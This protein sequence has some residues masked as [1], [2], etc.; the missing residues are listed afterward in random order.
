MWFGGMRRCP[1]SAGQRPALR[2]R[3]AGRTPA[4]RASAGAAGTSDHATAANTVTNNAVAV[5]LT[6]RQAT[7]LAATKGEPFSCGSLSS[8]RR[9]S[10]A[11]QASR[12]L[13]ADRKVSLGH[14]LIEPLSALAITATVTF[15]YAH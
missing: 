3:H 9:F 6:A 11:S 8:A 2:V 5:R 15:G 12:M 4:V 1:S 10:D 13:R 14:S 7:K